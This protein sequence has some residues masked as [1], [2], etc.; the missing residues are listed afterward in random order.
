[1][2][3]IGVLWKT[4]SNFVRKSR[5]PPSRSRKHGK[6]WVRAFGKLHFVN[7]T[8]EDRLLIRKRPKILGDRITIPWHRNLYVFSRNLYRYTAL[9]SSSFPTGSG[10]RE[11]HLR[12]S[13][14][15]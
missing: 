3:Q 5:L 10:V 13:R 1:F 6:T 7:R 4:R 15:G 9:S 8:L 14:A 2:T 11:P 12:L